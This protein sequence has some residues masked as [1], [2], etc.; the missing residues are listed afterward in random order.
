MLPELPAAGTLQGCASMGWPRSVLPEEGRAGMGS[1]L[2]FEPKH[3][4]RSS[5]RRCCASATASVR[6]TAWKVQTTLF[7]RD[8]YTKCSAAMIKA[9]SQGEGSRFKG[10][11]LGGEAHRYVPSVGHVCRS[12]TWSTYKTMLGDLGAHGPQMGAQRHHPLIEKLPWLAGQQR[13]LPP[14]ASTPRGTADFLLSLPHK[15]HSHLLS[16]LLFP[17]P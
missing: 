16:P 14:P 6:V 12:H 9:P 15:Q 5:S 7:I 11:P 17:M 13:A 3:Q 2:L 4:H 8:I 1:F 10:L